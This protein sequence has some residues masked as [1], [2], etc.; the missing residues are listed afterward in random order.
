MVWH[1]NMFYVVY[2]IKLHIASK[3]SWNSYLI[4]IFW[5]WTQK[6]SL[7]SKNTWTRDTRAICILLYQTLKSLLYSKNT[8]HKC[9]LIHSNV[10]LYTFIS[11][12]H[13]QQNKYASNI[14]K[15]LMHECKRCNVKMFV[16]CLKC[17]SVA[18]I[19]YLI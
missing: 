9:T 1:K 17:M 11:S 6:S 4:S 10:I 2:C 5:Y 19:D 3:K 18:L 13:Q 7:Y 8:W 12:S 14:S 16:K 15:Y